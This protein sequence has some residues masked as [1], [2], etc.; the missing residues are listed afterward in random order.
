MPYTITDG[1]VSIDTSKQVKVVRGG[2]KEVRYEEK[3]EQQPKQEVEK[4]D[5][6]EYEN[7][8]KKLRRKQNEK[9]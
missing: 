3:P 9:Q 7:R 1:V 4:I 8:I 2:Y 5:F 6:S